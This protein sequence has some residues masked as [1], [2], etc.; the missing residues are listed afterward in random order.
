MRNALILCLLLSGL[1]ALASQLSKPAE[2]CQANAASKKKIIFLAGGCSH[3]FGEHEYRAACLLLARNLEKHFSGQVET[4]VYTDSWPTADDAFD[5][6][7]AIVMFLEGSTKHLTL[8][9][10]NIMDSLMKKG[11][12]L[13]CLHFAVHVPPGPAGEHFKNWIGGYYE[14]F[15]SVNPFWKPEFLPFP[16][17]P[18]LNGVKPFTIRDEWYYHMRFKDS[19]VTPILS[20]IPPQSIMNLPGGHQSNEFVRQ[21]YGQPQSLAW[22]IQREDGGRGFGFTGGHYHRNWAHDDYRKLVLNA[23]AWTA[24]IEVPVNGVE[25]PTPTTG[26]LD[27]NVDSK[28]CI[29]K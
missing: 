19:G 22:A 12:G 1:N 27:A 7:A 11:I 13:A 24:N 4:V 10:L 9:R 18:I 16:E 20:A 15:W 14:T 2:K 5:N 28:P 26:Q 8:P 17:H 25:S 21:E 23:I 6:V 3:G 29:V